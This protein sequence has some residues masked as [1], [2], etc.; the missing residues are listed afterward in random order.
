[1][2]IWELILGAAKLIAVS[3]LEWVG[4]FVL[5]LPGCYAGLLLV[6]AGMGLSERVLR[7][8]GMLAA[9]RFRHW[10]LLVPFL[11]L[12]PA[13][14]VVVSDRTEF[15]SVFV[16]QAVACPL[17]AL[18]GSSSVLLTCLVLRPRRRTGPRA[19]LNTFAVRCLHTLAAGILLSAPLA[20]VYIALEASRSTGL[21]RWTGFLWSVPASLAVLGVGAGIVAAAEHLERGP[22]QRSVKPR[23]L[24]LRPFESEHQYFEEGSAARGA[25]NLETA[26][27]EAM[28][29]SWH[30]FVTLGNPTDRI[31]PS[32]AV[33]VYL[34][35]TGWQDVV[36]RMISEARCVLAVPSTAPSTLWEFTHIR[37]TEQQQELFVLTPP[38]PPAATVPDESPEE[39]LI[40]LVLSL[41][42]RPLVAVRGRARGALPVPFQSW[43]VTAQAL[44][45]AGFFPGEDPG[46]GALVGFDQEGRALL[47]VTGRTSV[48]ACLRAASR[49]L[50]PDEGL[51]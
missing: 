34:P 45:A 19:A 41:F 2:S 3:V 4:F 42:L 35:D 44:A 48:R 29:E 50:A 23:T 40:G 27:A 10:F 16:E 25:V 13:G 22:D 1:M 33:R 24:F 15:S 26:L 31:A 51:Y 49:Y 14:V 38:A 17:G 6:A 28:P 5:A 18:L 46:P 39:H 37:R 21:E 30:P 11:V 43:Q 47:L 9:P 8:R 32:G 12:C 20:G 7:K 36:V